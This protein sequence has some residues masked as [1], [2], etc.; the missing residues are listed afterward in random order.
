ML[1]CLFFVFYLPPPPFLLIPAK[2]FFH[3]RRLAQ[4]QDLYYAN[5][6]HG[7]SVRTP[8][9]EIWSPNNE[10]QHS[11]LDTSKF[12]DAMWS[13]LNS[14]LVSVIAS[15]ATVAAA[16][17][18]SG[19]SGKKRS[20][21]VTAVSVGPSAQANDASA[22]QLVNALVKS[23]KRCVRLVIHRLCCPSEDRACTHVFD[24]D[25]HHLRWQLAL[26]L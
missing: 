21:A 5:L 3:I 19:S 10:M 22:I 20:A 4:Q 14:V 2:W 12:F 18:S 15:Q 9:S 11:D 1:A 6:V 8:L 7:A 24:E 25:R 13:S 23:V 16:A 17:A 26:L